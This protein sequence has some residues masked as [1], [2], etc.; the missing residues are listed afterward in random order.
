MDD[1]DKFAEQISQS[2]GQ[3]EAALGSDGYKVMLETQQ[4]ANN[5]SDARVDRT[6]AVT[7]ALRVCI[8]LGLVMSIP[9]QIVLWK[10]ALS[11]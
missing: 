1:S 9:V 11:Y 3:I 6:L 8:L 4:K 7:T 5:Q 10:W 2:Y